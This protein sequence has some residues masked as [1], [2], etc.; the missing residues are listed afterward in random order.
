MNITIDD[1]KIHI[2]NLD[3][4]TLI[5][6]L[7]VLR[8]SYVGTLH[9]YK[10]TKEEAIGLLR[11]QFELSGNEQMLQMS[12]KEMEEFCANELSIGLSIIKFIDKLKEHGISMPE[13]EIK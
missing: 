2:T 6:I 8:F 10:M 3:K 13:I 12:E 9:L 7:S 5:D 4:S 11:D 1:D